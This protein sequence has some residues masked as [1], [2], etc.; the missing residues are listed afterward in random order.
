MQNSIMLK[1][2]KDHEKGK[3][4]RG[5]VPQKERVQKMR[6]EYDIY[7][8]LLGCKEMKKTIACIDINNMGK[9]AEFI[10]MM[11]Y[12]SYKGKRMG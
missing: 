2:E 4:N 7:G 8:N 11:R 3:E 10:G 9:K 5:Q 12:H 1:C 6:M